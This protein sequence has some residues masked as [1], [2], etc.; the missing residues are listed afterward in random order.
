MNREKKRILGNVTLLL[1]STFFSYTS[2]AQCPTLLWSDEFNGTSLNTANWNYDTGS[3]GVNNE[4]EIYTSRPQNVSV[5]GGNLV[6]TALQENYGGY[7]YTSGKIDSYGKQNFKYGRF[8]ARIQLPSTQGLWPAFWMMPENSVYGSWPASGEIDIMEEIGSNPYKDFGT[9]HYG[10]N[11][12]N[13]Q[14]SGGTYTG[15]NNLSTGFHT[16]A[17]EWKPDT[18]NW[19]LDEHNFYTVTATSISPQAWP[20]DQNFFIILNVAVGGWFGGN[21]DATTIF[22]QTML[23]DYVRVYSNPHTVFING[24]D[25]ALANESYSFTVKDPQATSFAWSVPP[26]STITSGQGTDSIQVMIGANSGIV[27]VAINTTACGAD[28]LT[29]N[30]PVLSN[31]CDLIFD[32]FESN[33]HI[34]YNSSTGTAYNPATANPSPNSVNSSSTVAFYTR[35][36]IQ[37]DL[38]YYAT[39]LINNSVDYENGNRTLYMNVNTNAPVGTVINWQFEN[40]EL[41]STQSYP[42]GRRAVF[43]GTTTMQNQWENIKFTL[44][45]TP[46]LTTAPTSIDQFTF[47]FA[48][49]TYTN[50]NF[51]LDNLIRTDKTACLATSTKTSTDTPLNIVVSPNPAHDEL[52]LSIAALTGKELNISLIDMLGVEYTSQK[53]TT[54][55]V[56]F[57]TTLNVSSL[58]PGLYILTIQHGENNFTSK[59]IVIQ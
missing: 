34:A 27:S 14:S 57:E 11:P 40:S 46:D 59:K 12:A 43:V 3:P 9:I 31:G 25:E 26:G 33:Q 35:N 21:P 50:Y 2:Q 55:G 6:I 17:V 7:S 30:L 4:L 8:E 49:N 42:I 19:Y 54:Q 44:S 24:K 18:I 56:S 48:P 38:L 51:Y 41:S 15:I 22:P 53:Y 1:F 47:L 36:T 39:D 52:S 45:S 28:T 10:P 58:P 20:F 29:K 32:D 37:Y 13:A 5:S 16:Y 23:V